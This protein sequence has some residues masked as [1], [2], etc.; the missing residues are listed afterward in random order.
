[1]DSVLD[2]QLVL[3]LNSAWQ[4][5]GHRTVKQAIVAMC[6]G[7]HG[8]PPA[9]ALDISLDD[10]GELISAIPT[11]WDDWVKLPVRASDL[12]ITTKLG[13]IRAPTII[14]TPR[15]HKM[16]L[17]RPKL[18]AKAIR[19]RDGDTCQYSGRKLSR[20]EGN[21]DHITPKSRGGRDDWG[22]LV[23]CDRS[24]NTKKSN[25]LNEEVGLK[26]IRVPKAPP[27]LPASATI[28]VALHPHH[29]PFIQ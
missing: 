16:P 18:T 21:I 11:K 28:K 22:N 20:K 29:K 3:S 26:L 13:R 2:K 15:F 23:W 5:I 8:T 10:N 12:S 27:A 1:M 24:L 25:S 19:E 4:A 7:I 17:R 9:L 6:G 14:V